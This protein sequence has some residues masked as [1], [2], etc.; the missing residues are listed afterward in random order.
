[1]EGWRSQVWKGWRTFCR[2]A[3]PAGAGHWQRL[4]LLAEPFLPAPS[5]GREQRAHRRKLSAGLEPG[6][7][8]RQLRHF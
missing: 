8:R 6:K 3:A 4:P 1:M 2:F 7:R 5:I